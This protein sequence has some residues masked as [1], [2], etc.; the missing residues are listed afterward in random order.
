MKVS[1][2][3]PLALVACLFAPLAAGCAAETGEEEP[4]V[5]ADSEDELVA[6]ADEHWFYNGAVPTLEQS[7]LTVSLKGNTARLTGLLPQGASVPAL[8]H[9]KTKAEG[10][11]TRIDLVYPIATARPGKSNSRPGTYAFQLAK[12]Y[13]PDGSAWTASEGEHFVPWGGF[14]FISYNGGI[15]VHGPIT[16]TSAVSA[17]DLNVWVLKRGAVSGGC[18]RMMG[19]HVVELAHAIGVNMRKVY[20]ANKIYTPPHAPVKVIADYDQY[21]G[22]AI[23]VDYPTDTGVVRPGKVLGADKVVMFGSWVASELPN[24]KD[25]PPNMKWEGGVAG[26]YYVFAEHAL[27]NTVCS[28]PK[29]DLAKLGAYAKLKGELPTNFCAQKACYLSALRAGRTPA[30]N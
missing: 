8:P 13:R 27:K 17:A 5:A 2:F 18:N 10:G 12:P 23:D 28:A 7:Q 19:E 30:C 29:A 24:G 3:A 20:V 15:A 4:V 26:D 1:R 25:L 14:P 11:R 16:S 21:D 9:A 22:K 6:K